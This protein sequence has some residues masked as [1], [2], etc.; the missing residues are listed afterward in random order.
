MCTRV[1]VGGHVPELLL[2]YNIWVLGI[3]LRLSGLKES[4][5]ML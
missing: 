1:G 5:L 3:E 4:N 2:F